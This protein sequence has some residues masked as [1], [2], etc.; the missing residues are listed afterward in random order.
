MQIALPFTESTVAPEVMI[1]L[2]LW[3]NAAKHQPPMVG[4][5]KCR[6][7]VDGTGPQMGYRRWWNGCTFSATTKIG[8]PD[9]IAEEAKHMAT[10]QPLHRIEWCGLL[11][12]HPDHYP[13]RLFM[14]ELSHA[15]RIIRRPFRLP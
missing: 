7:V 11:A 12:R 15:P 10:T 5:W 13:Y 3:M 8:V 2:T 4:W 9:E 14:K 6:N 1:G